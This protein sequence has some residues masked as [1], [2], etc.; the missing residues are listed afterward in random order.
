MMMVGK[1]TRWSVYTSQYGG[2]RY[3]RLFL[4]S[5][6]DQREFDPLGARHSPKRRSDTWTQYESEVGNQSDPDD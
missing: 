4:S 3:T 2:D 1:S 6:H 5:H